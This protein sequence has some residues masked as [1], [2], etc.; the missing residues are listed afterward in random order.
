MNVAVM[1]VSV[2]AD[3]LPFGWCAAA[4]CG[5]AAD[6]L[7]LDGCVVDVKAVGEGA[8]HAVADALA[9]GHEHL[10]DGDVTGKG[11]RLGSEAPDM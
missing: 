8:L 1:V 9:L 11:V 6:G 4:V 3:G 7:E 5:L 2:C 10:V